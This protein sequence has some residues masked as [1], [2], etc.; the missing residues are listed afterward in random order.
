MTQ[1]VPIRI[2]CT[3]DALKLAEDMQRKLTAEQHAVEISCGRQS[4][5]DI[6]KARAEAVILIW[7]RDAPTS[8]YM[9][10]WAAR[11]PPAR[12]I[13]VNRGRS[14]PSASKRAGI[15]FCHWE[16]ERGASAA[17]HA[18]EER[19]RGVTRISQ[20]KK[21][22]PR[23]AA[24]VLAVLS[25][26]AV[27]D[28]AWLRMQDERRPPVQPLEEPTPIAMTQ[29]PGAVGGEGGPLVAREP[30][31]RPEEKALVFYRVRRVQPLDAP[32]AMPL[33]DVETAPD[34]EIERDPT[35]LDRIVSFAA[36]LRGRDAGQSER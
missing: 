20:P 18:L 24:M 28:A 5:G 23:R 7:S 33:S 22:P 11:I 6:E 36:P 17:W 16:G 8:H 30:A 13:D 1:A 15:D 26:L 21:P 10:Q 3:R 29:T 2:V 9:L 34:F 19:L 12:L 14:N 25:A 31:S 4:L 32:R 27:G 35:M